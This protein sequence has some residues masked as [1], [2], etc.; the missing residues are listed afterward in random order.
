MQKQK[1]PLVFGVFHKKKKTK[2]F[3]EKALYK[4]GKVCYII[5]NENH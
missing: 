4:E 2:S 3:F 1:F 5:D